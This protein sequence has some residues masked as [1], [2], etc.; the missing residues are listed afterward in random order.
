VIEGS[1][2]IILHGNA[3]GKLLL[4]KGEINKLCYMLVN[5][6]STIQPIAF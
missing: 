4:Q 1:E 2:K 5:P 6:V 3:L